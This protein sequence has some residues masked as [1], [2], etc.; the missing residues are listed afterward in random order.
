MRC[1][2]GCDLACHARTAALLSAHRTAPCRQS[3]DASDDSSAS[4]TSGRHDLER[5]GALG[6]AWLGLTFVEVRV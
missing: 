5:R 6:L 2:S 3:A 1:I 4:E